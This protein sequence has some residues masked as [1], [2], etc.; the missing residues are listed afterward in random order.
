MATKA[1]QFGHLALQ[2]FHLRSRPRAEGLLAVLVV[3]L[4]PAVEQARREIVFPTDLCW[5]LLTQR[6]LLADLE[7]E[8][9]CEAA[10]SWHSTSPISAAVYCCL[11]EDDLECL[12][13]PSC[14]VVQTD[15][16]TAKM[17]EA[18][19]DV[20]TTFIT[21]RQTSKATQPGQR[22]LD[23]PAI[24]TQAL[25]ALDTLARDSHLD[26]PLVQRLAA[27]R[28]VIGLV[29]IQLGW[30]FARSTPW[31][32]DRLHDVEQRFKMDAVMAVGGS[33]ED[34]QRDALTLDDQMVFAA[35]CPLGVALVREIPTDLLAPLF[36]GILA[37]SRLA[38]FQSIRS[39]SPRWSSNAWWSR[40][41]TPASCQSRR[42]RQQVTPLPQ[43]ISW[44]NISQ[45]MPDLST[46]MMPVR[47]ARSGTRGRPPFG[48]GISAGSNGAM[49]SHSSS[50]TS[51]LAIMPHASTLQ[52]RF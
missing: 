3:L 51:G 23:D 5:A 47:A 12:S 9:S 48:F 4:A 10:A 38:R 30:P 39:V 22:A 25:A 37:L 14:E 50:G 17:E 7:L 2:R 20:G 29:S 16:C 52:L 43:P 13:K 26:V 36:A 46:K 35:G 1:F 44:G 21:D 18:F 27:A 11:R 49:I 28:D 32:F 45:G 24:A 41:Q 6:Y 34:G 8:F 31:A 33:Q 40:A 42:R 19:V 15:E